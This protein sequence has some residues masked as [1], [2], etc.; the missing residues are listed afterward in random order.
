[1]SGVERKLPGLE[2]KSATGLLYRQTRQQ[3]VR[4]KAMKLNGGLVSRTVHADIA[5][6]ISA[7]A[8]DS[9]VA[10][11]LVL[12]VKQRIVLVGGVR[13]NLTNAEFNMLELL[14][15]QSGH[16]VTKAELTEA[17]VSRALEKFD[18]SVD[19]HISNLRKKIGL[20]IQGCRRIDTVRGIGY[21]YTGASEVERVGSQSESYSEKRSP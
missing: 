8:H 12:R 20:T 21:T 16:V 13:I 10:D 17:G 15:R 18:R 11:D 1:M 3:V 5:D 4:A 7:V 2:G 9:L 6:R 14:L 19:M